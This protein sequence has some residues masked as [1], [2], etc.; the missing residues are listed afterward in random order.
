MGYIKDR[1]NKEINKYDYYVVN[2]QTGKGKKID[3]EKLVKKA[4]KALIVAALGSTILT[5]G[6]GVIFA[7][8]IAEFK[9]KREYNHEVVEASNTDPHVRELL[10]SQGCCY[11]AYPDKD[12]EFILDFNPIA[13]KCDNE[14]CKVCSHNRAVEEEINSILSKDSASRKIVEGHEYYQ[15]RK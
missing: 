6:A 10:S 13:R 3:T 15:G 7:E 9:N 12:L 1:A 2:P 8:E 5:A 14:D 11:V 4:K